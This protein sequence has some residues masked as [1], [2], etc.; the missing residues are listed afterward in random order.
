MALGA[1]C[2]R[3]HGAVPARCQRGAPGVLAGYSPDY[4]LIIP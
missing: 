2:W 4:P 1:G 3:D